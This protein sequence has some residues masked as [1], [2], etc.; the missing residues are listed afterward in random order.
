MSQ[1]SVR[2]AARRAAL[3]VQAARR[4]ERVA[5]Q[6]RLEALAVDVLVAI[7]E[8]DAAVQAAERRAG[9]ALRDMTDRERLSLRDVTE[10]CGGLITLREAM[11]LRRLVND[12]QAR[13]PDAADA[14]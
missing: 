12:T 3:D 5:R 2:Q 6:R 1:Q 11:R 8:R 13:D 4:R 7:S 10:W 9:Q 14:S